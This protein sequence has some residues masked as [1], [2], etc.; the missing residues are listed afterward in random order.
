MPTEVI[1][2]LAGLSV[3]QAVALATAVFSASLV[4]FFLLVDVQQFVPQ[5]V[6]DAHLGEWAVLHAEKAV[7]QARIALVAALLIAVAHLDSSP[8]SKKGDA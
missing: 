3:E 8:I 2:A 6:R 4:P 1:D 7:L 5:R